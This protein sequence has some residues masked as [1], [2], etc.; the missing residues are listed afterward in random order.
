MYHRI[1]PT[2]QFVFANLQPVSPVFAMSSTNR[3]CRRLGTC[4]S[5]KIPLQLALSNKSMN[6]FRKIT[7]RNG[8]NI[9]P[10]FVPTLQLKK[11]DRPPGLFTHDFSCAYLDRSP[12]SVLFLAR[13]YNSIVCWT[14]SKAFEKSTNIQ[15]ILPFFL[16]MCV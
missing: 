5:T 2:H 4:S 11:S 14:Q 16:L 7:N 15:Y 12:F 9:H 8:L 10:C 3:S 1:D 6:S 13:V